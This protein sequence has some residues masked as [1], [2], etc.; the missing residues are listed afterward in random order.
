MLQGYSGT[1]VLCLFTT[2]LVI[3][4]PMFLDP[5]DIISFSTCWVQ[6]WLELQKCSFKVQMPKQYTIP[7]NLG[8]LIRILLKVPLNGYKGLSIKQFTI[9]WTYLNLSGR[10]SH[11][12]WNVW[13]NLVSVSRHVPRLNLS[14]SILTLTILSTFTLLIMAKCIVVYCQYLDSALVQQS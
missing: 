6:C 14:T 1:V 7:A 4:L 12:Q 8:C 10:W 2:C 9:L 13:F 5:L 3:G 11:Y